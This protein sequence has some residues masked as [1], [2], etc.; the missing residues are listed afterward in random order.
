MF[1]L[2]AFH[3][4]VNTVFT[5]ALCGSPSHSHG[6]LPLLVRGLDDAQRDTALLSGAG[7]DECSTQ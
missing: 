6:A 5:R 7:V 1:I 2:A 4:A 3:V